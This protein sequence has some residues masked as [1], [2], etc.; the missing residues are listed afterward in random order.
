MR[1]NQGF[2]HLGD[3]IQLYLDIL[4]FDVC[5]V[6]SCGIFVIAQNFWS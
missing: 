4:T 5:V 1:P 2:I 6:T 3:S